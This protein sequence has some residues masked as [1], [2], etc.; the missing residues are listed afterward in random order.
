[1]SPSDRPTDLTD[2]AAREVVASA[3]E[4][5][6]FWVSPRERTAALRRLAQALGEHAVVLAEAGIP[7]SLAR[8]AAG[9]AVRHGVEST[10]FVAD[11]VKAAV[12]RRAAALL[13]HL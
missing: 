3:R 8:E 12:L 1:V 11:A 4:F 6:H 2:R 7:A 5:C 10:P 9:A 13:S